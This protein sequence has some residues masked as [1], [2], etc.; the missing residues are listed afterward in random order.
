VVEPTGILLDNYRK[1]PVVLWDHGFGGINVPIGK[2]EES[3]GNLAM[4]VTDQAIVAGC[5][6]ANTPEAEQIF[7]LI[8]QKII[9]ATSIGFRPLEAEPRSAG[10]DR[11]GLH[12]KLWELFEWSW[13]IVPDNP[14]ALAKV[15]NRGRL[16]G[17]TICEPLRKSLTAASAPRPIYGKG[18]RSPVTGRTIEQCRALTGRSKTAQIPEAAQPAIAEFVGIMQDAALALAN[19]LVSDIRQAADTICEAV[20]ERMNGAPA[21]GIAQPGETEPPYPDEGEPR[22]MR[23]L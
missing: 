2:C 13:V 14:D 7:E 16:A 10:W 11:P 8:V 23:Y 21:D 1:N 6:F 19:R 20:D 18:W 17:R 4:T 22:P 12:I 5:Y 9:R 3:D 15:L